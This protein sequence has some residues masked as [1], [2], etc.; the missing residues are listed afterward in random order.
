[1]RFQH[2]CMGGL[3]KCRGNSPLFVFILFYIFSFFYPLF[4]HDTTPDFFLLF[5]VFIENRFVPCNER[6]RFN[7]MMGEKVTRCGKPTDVHCKVLKGS[8]REHNVWET[9]EEVLCRRQTGEGSD[10]GVLPRCAF[11]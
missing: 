1:M 10:G 3:R 8:Y 4:C 11:P 2:V 6:V 5:F 7:N 9:L